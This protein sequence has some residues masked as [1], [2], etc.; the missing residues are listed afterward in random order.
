MGIL[1][2]QSIAD[3]VRRYGAAEERPQVVWPNGILAST[4]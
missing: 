1:D 4:V 3:E 2:R